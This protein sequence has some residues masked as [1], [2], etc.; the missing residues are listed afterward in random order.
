MRAFVRLPCLSTIDE[1]LDHCAAEGLGVPTLHMCEGPSMV[2]GIAELVT[3]AGRLERRA[4]E[5]VATA[6]GW[7]P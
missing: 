2:V 4:A 3:E 6:E 5:P 1:M 7:R